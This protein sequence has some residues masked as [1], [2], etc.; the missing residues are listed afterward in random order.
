MLKVNVH[1]FAF[2]TREIRKCASE[3]ALWQTSSDCVQF[4]CGFRKFNLKHSGEARKALQVKES[5]VLCKDF[6]FQRISNKKRYRRHF[7][8]GLERI[9]DR[10]AAVQ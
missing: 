9:A 8:N 3:H 5:N 1:I 2:L 6:S 10:S 4:C 7:D